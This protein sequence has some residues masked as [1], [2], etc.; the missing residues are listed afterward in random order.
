MVAFLLVPYN[1]V[2]FCYLEC[3]IVVSWSVGRIVGWCVGCLVGWLV[4]R[5]VGVLCRWWFPLFM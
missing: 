3:L 2:R 5:L 4:G 1:Y